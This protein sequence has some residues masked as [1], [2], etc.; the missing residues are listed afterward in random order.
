MKANKYHTKQLKP[1]DWKRLRDM[2]LKALK[3][4]ESMYL[5]S[6]EKNKNFTENQWKNMISGPDK[7]VFGLFENENHIGIGAIYASQNDPSG[8]TAMLAMG[9]IVPEYRRQGLSHKLYEARIDWAKKHPIIEKLYA[10]HREG[11]EASRKAMIEHGFKPDGKERIRFGDG[12]E[13]T[14]YSYALYLKK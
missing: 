6:Y 11:N 4:C 5:A 10:S 7:A 8:K 13:D 3:E 14:D 9:F 12:Q 1:C 2:R